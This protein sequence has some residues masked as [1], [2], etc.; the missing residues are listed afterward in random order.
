MAMT[1]VEAYIRQ[2]ALRRGMDPDAVVR[3]ANTEG[4]VRDPFRQAEY[5]KNGY[6]EP[7]TGPFQML[8]GGKGTGFPEGL[9][10]KMI[11]DT[12]VDPRQDWKAGINYSLDTAQKEGW[13]QW[14]G[15]KN[16]GLDRWYGVNS[17]A[18]PVQTTYTPTQQPA[19]TSVEGIASLPT[20]NQAINDTAQTTAQA[21][22]TAPANPMGGIFGALLQGAMQQQTPQVPEDPM[23][24]MADSKPVEQKVAETSQTPDVYLDDLR[25]RYL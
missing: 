22:A 15:P 23:V 9:G 17:K 1:E 2:E 3:V 18:P 12:G 24:R 11:R 25:K 19:Q 20:V 21:T 13:R 6:K 7:S 14:Y 4:G 10:N 8:V 5:S 16:A